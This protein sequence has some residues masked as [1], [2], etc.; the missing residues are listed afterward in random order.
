MNFLHIFSNSIA[1]SHRSSQSGS[2]TQDPS[3]VGEDEP[4]KAISAQDKK[5]LIHEVRRQME[6]EKQF[7]HEVVA[8]EHF[9][10][11]M[12]RERRLIM[13]TKLQEKKKVKS[14]SLPVAAKSKSKSKPK[15]KHRKKK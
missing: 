11:K 12:M 5:R 8:R 1:T 9:L 15:S 10:R 7:R 6:D 3:I 14:T 2:T 4:R 13:N